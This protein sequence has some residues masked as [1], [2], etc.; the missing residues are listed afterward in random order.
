MELSW[1][2]MSKKADYIQEVARR[3]LQQ[4][5]EGTTDV[6]FVYSRRMFE[7]EFRCP[8]DTAH[9]LTA[10]DF[11]V[12]LKFLDRDK[13]ECVYDSQVSFFTINRK[14]PDS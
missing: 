7:R 3:V 9:P 6:G 14:P 11:E 1:P 2:F 10:K 12:L 5:S 13:G 8:P 4:V